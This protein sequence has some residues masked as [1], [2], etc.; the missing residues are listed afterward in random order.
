MKSKN[1]NVRISSILIDRFCRLRDEHL[2]IVNNHH[3]LFYS[4]TKTTFHICLFLDYSGENKKFD[5]DDWK[6]AENVR[7]ISSKKKKISSNFVFAYLD[8]KLY[9]RYGNKNQTKSVYSP[10]KR[11]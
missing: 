9:R 8:V 10:T 1:E 2:P 3:F 11:L 7:K 4:N 6:N 5:N